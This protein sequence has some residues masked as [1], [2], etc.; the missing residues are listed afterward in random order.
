LTFVWDE[1]KALSNRTRHGVAFEEA[2]EVLFDPFVRQEDASAEDEQRDRFVGYSKSGRLL[3]VV[4]TERAQTIRIIS[5]RTVTRA[6]RSEYE[7]I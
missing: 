5:A 3:L 2:A 6:E 1:E 7:E 4:F